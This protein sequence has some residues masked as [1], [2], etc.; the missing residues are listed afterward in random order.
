MHHPLLLTGVWNPGSVEGALHIAEI[1]VI[2][3]LGDSLLA[4]DSLLTG[5]G[6]LTCDSFLTADREYYKDYLASSDHHQSGFFRLKPVHTSA[7]YII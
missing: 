1:A 7:I 4:G 2:C 6:F 3:T 5:D